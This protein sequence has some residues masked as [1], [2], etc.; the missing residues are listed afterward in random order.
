MLNATRNPRPRGGHSIRLVRAFAG[1]KPTLSDSDQESVSRAKDI[2]IAQEWLSVG[3][4]LADVITVLEVRHR[5][6]FPSAMCR[7]YATE[8]VSIGQS[9]PRPKAGRNPQS[10]ES[11]H[12]AA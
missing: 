5:F 8:I 1:H 6:D 3:A 4:P 10:K 2:R 7:A 11:T 9:L 12:A